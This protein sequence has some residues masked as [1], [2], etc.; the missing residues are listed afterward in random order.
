MPTLITVTLAATLYS[1]WIRRSSWLSRWEAG[2]SL[3]VALQGCAVLLMSPWAAT[4]FGPHLY[5]VFG[6]WNLQ[7]LLGHICLIL[8][9]TAIIYH[10]LARLADGSLVTGIFGRHIAA[11]LDLGVPLLVA[12]F[13]VA[14]EEYHA[15]LFPAHVDTIWLGAYWLVLGGLLIY[16]LSYAGRVLFI[17]R[18]DSRSKATANVYLIAIALGVAAN[19]MQMT[20]AWAGVDITLPIWLCICLGA[21]GFAY[22]AARSW[23]ARINWFNPGSS[24]VG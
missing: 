2:A 4:T 13:I 14:D 24:P 8:A 21:I 12:V 17:M 9:A 11:P 23:R 19:A 5:R 3:S 6:L 10:V 16:L 20:T 18:E 7:H 22:A 1:L 15:D